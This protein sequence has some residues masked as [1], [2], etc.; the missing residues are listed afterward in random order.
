MSYSGVVASQGEFWREQRRHSMHILRDFGFGRSILEDRILEEISFFIKE[1]HKNTCEPFYPQPTIQRSVSNVIA[2]VSFGRR[3]D[4]DDP[5]F[6]QYM[7]I[8]NY[9]F[10]RVGNS[11]I[12]TIFPFLRYILLTILHNCLIIHVDILSLCHI[13]IPIIFK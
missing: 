7:Y 4:Y 6:K 12:I 1:L 2:S 9:V 13:N 11:G 5:R 3:M 8:M 10:K